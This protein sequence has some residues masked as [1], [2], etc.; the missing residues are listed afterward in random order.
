MDET[1][2]VITTSGSNSANVGTVHMTMTSNKNLIVGTGTN[3]DGPGYYYEMD[4]IQKEVPGTTYSD[5]DVRNKSWVYHELE[6]GGNNGWKY[7]NGT[8]DAAGAMTISSET[9]PS[10]TTTP[11]ATGATIAVNTNG[12]VTVTGGPGA[13]SLL[14]Y[15][16]FLSADKKTIVGT[17]TDDWG[18]GDIRYRLM[19]IQ[20][21]GQTYTAGT[22]PA[23][24]A[25][26]HTLACGAMPFW[27]HY[28]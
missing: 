6:V 11:G 9:T 12:V 17:F 20:V 1:T 24:T 16:G 5:A 25:A 18:G 15:Q 28:H 8:I 14:T 22:F 21:T 7:G 23:L 26:T 10:G 19:I 4:I 2:G 3:G 13:E 27:I